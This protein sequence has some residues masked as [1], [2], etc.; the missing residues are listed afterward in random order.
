MP[1][2]TPQILTI[3]LIGLAAGTL[4]GLTGLGGGAIVVPAL[5]Y[6]LGFSM[7]M[8]QGT[9]LAMMIPPIGLLAV[10]GY[11]Q[12]GF[13]DIRTAAILVVF[14]VIGGFLGSRLAV[15]LSETVLRRGFAIFLILIAIKML[16]QEAKS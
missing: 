1:T 5:V 13:V 2:L 6:L 12:K 7:H 10:W 14:F 8:A 16:I 9:S 15:N 4:S 11:Y 3:I